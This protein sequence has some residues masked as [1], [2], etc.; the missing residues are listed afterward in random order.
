M[1][2]YGIISH[3]GYEDAAVAP[4]DF[5]IAPIPAM[6]KV[7]ATCGLKVDDIAMWDINEAF[8]VN[9]YSIQN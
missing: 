4:M 1:Y 3:T 9:I 8:S 6:Q 5:P 7:L 2:I